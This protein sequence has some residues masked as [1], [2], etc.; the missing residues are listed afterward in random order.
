MSAKED[1][2]TEHINNKNDRKVKLNVVLKLMNKLTSV[3]Y[4][5]M[6]LSVPLLIGFAIFRSATGKMDRQSG[7][8][9]MLVAGMIIGGLMFLFLILKIITSLLDQGK[10]E[11]NEEG[12]DSIT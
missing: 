7:A 9:F 8:Q 11:H 2:N 12:P 1:V 10:E 4:W 3:A 5:L 6:A